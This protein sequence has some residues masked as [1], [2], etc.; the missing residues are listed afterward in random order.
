M[1]RWGRGKRR[2]SYW[3]RYG[4]DDY[5]DEEYEDGEEP[6]EDE[7]VDYD[8]FGYYNYRPRIKARGGIR[9][10]SK[11][12]AFGESW[13][14]KRWI[15]TLESFNIGARLTR[16]RSYARGGQV[17]SID[18]DKGVIRSKV[19]GSYPRPYNVTIKVKTLSDADWKRLVD[20]LSSQVIFAAKLLAGEMPQEIE[21]TFTGAGLSLFP[22]KRGDLQTDCSCPDYSNPCKHIAAVYYLLG[23]EFDRDPFLIFK[24][25]GATREEFIRMLGASGVAKEKIVT[26]AAAVPRPPEPISAGAAS[27]WNCGKLPDDFFGE[28]RLAPVSAAQP[29]RLGNFPFWRGSEHFLDAITPVYS[30]AA[31]TGLGVFLGETEM[32]RQAERES[33]AERA[34]R[35]GKRRTVA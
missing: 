19:Q 7:S 20:A 9:A 6:D 22:E 1:E 35:A 25:R 34:R 10:Q 13:W 21:E 2:N 24:F 28:V 33:H 15:A 5:E 8:R 14:A 23:E 29:K 11:R 31:L 3:N 30:N 17:L 27:F 32:E 16:G 12:G 18:I 26:E 4:E